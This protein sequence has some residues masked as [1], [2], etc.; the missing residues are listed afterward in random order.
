MSDKVQQVKDQ[1]GLFQKVASYIPGYRGYKEKEVRR[2]T[3]RLVR[4]TASG[5]MAK[6]LDEYRR[7][8][9]SLDLPAQDRDYADSIMARLDTVRERTARAVA[10][11]AGIFDAVKVLEG[12]LDKL[13]ELDGNLV[14]AAQ[15]LLATCKALDSPSPTVEGF[16]V[17]SAAALDGIQ[18]IEGILEDRE[19]LLKNP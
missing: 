5:F 10:G 9:A 7:P 15:N 6:A 19:A 3:D 11:Y 17:G 18:K 2:E 16:T 13:V 8:L 12:R 4:A 1:M 14:Q